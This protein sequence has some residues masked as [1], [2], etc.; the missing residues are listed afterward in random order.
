MYTLTRRDALQVA[1]WLQSNGIDAR[2]YFSDVTADGFASSDDYRQHLEAD[3]LD[4]RLK[5]L[6]ATAALGMGYDK[7]DLGFVVH[8]QA[9]GSIVAYYQQVGRAGRA[10][11]RAYGV[12][13]AGQ[14]DHDIH[15][16]SGA[17]H[18]L[19][20]AMSAPFSTSSPAATGS[21]PPRSN[22]R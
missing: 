11:D 1:E 6:V 22:A 13:L 16:Y 15:D 20:S 8:F 14:E 7:P 9:P 10:I 19:T 21:P 18:F 3:L 4:N 17:P 2:A 5:V 12:L